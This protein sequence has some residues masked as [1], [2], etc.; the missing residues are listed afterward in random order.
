[1][2]LRSFFFGVTLALCFVWVFSRPNSTLRQYLP[3]SSGPLFTEAV[4]AGLGADETN[5]IEVYKNGKES[6]V[7]ITSTQTMFR[8][9]FFFGVEREQ[10]KELGSGF[11]INSDGQIL[12]NNHVVSGN[13][14]VEVTLPDKSVHKAKILQRDRTNDLALIKIDV[15]KKLPA[16]NLGDSDRLQVGQKVLAIGNPFGLA[17]TLTVGVVSTLDRDIT[18]ENSKL[19]GMIQTD[20]AINSGNSGGPL[21]D[22]QGSVIGINTAIYTP[23]GEGG[24]SVGI[25]FAMPINR[26]KRLLEDYRSGKRPAARLGVSTYYFAGE[27][28]QALKYPAKGGLLIFRVENGSAADRAGL[29]GATEYVIVGNQR[30]PYGGDFIT[31]IEGKDV[32]SQ[33]GVARAIRGKHAGDMV[34]LTIIRG[35]RTMNIKITLL[36]EEIV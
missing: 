16:L 24:G 28:A 36:S 3:G 8:D 23:Q 21:L 25:G 10:V 32:D 31:Q 1:M 15:N 27:W 26:A 34:E 35:G 4:A 5:N 29:R 33:E 7:Y 6:V 13:A 22:S 19:E 11:L 17:G 18:S 2:K 9:T 20:A 14:T 12:T 30:I